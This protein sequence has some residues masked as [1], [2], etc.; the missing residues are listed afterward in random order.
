MVD[1]AVRHSRLMVL[2]G[3]NHE[4]VELQERHL[5]CTVHG[6]KGYLKTQCEVEVDGLLNVVCRDTDVLYARCE[7]FNVHCVYCFKNLWFRFSE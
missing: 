7:V 6:A 3:L 5:L 2:I 1:G 4:I